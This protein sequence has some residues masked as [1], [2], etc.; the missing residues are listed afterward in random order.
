MAD[1]FQSKKFKA[2]LIASLTALLGGYAS[3]LADTGDFLK[4]L[5]LV[6]WTLVISPWFLYVGAQ[7]V[8][9][10]GKERAIAEGKIKAQTAAK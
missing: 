3:G 9:D 4:A 2:T 7:G 5:A 8:A 10:I 1:L 6:D